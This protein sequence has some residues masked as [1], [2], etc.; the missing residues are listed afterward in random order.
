MVSYAHPSW[1]QD[2]YVATISTIVETDEPESEIKPA[3]DLL[4]DILEKFIMV[5][6]LYLPC[7]SGTKSNLFITESYDPTCNFEYSVCEVLNI[8]KS[9]FGKDFDLAWSVDKAEEVKEVKEEY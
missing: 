2:L 5:S 3:L 9:I 7:Q 1:S 6:D 8:Y 4:G